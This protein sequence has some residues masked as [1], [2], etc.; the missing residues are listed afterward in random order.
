M[1]EYDDDGNEIPE[2]EGDEGIRG[3][4]QAKK[5]AEAR[6]DA[7]EAAAAEAQTAVKELAFLK[8]GLPEDSKTAAYFRNTYTGDL[9][10]EAIKQAAAEAG[11]I[12][13][14]STEASESIAGQSQMA[15]G[16][17]GAQAPHF[18]SVQIGPSHAPVTVPAED[19]EMYQEL[20][21]AAKRGFQG[22]QQMSEIL[23]RHGHE[24]G[25][26]ETEPLHTGPNTVPLANQQNRII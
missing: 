9:T 24:G 15:Q 3:I 7:A 26:G 19:A 16:M 4:R 17:Q 18:G 6:A 8:A 21:A 25:S 2:P 5:A 22:I 12:P 11:I 20:E 13:D 10:P 14:Q 1:P 23:R